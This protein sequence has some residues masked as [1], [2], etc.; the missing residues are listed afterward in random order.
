[1]VNPSAIPLRLETDDLRIAFDLL[2]WIGRKEVD[3][4]PASLRRA[5]YRAT[6]P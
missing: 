3:I 5:L 6:D 1:M 2:S 4:E